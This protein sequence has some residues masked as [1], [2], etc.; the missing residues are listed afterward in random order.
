[1]QTKQILTVI[2]IVATAILAGAAIYFGLQ[3]QQE[4]SQ[5]PEGAKAAVQCGAGTCDNGQ[6]YGADCYATQASC[7]ERTAEYC[8]DFGGPGSGGGPTSNCPECGDGICNGQENAAS[9]P[10]DCQGQVTCNGQVLSNPKC[11]SGT[12]SEGYDGHVCEGP[13]GT[14]CVNESR[15][16]CNE[17]EARGYASST[18]CGQYD[19][20]CDG[21]VHEWE[22]FT[23]GCQEVIA[24]NGNC[25]GGLPCEGNATCN[26]DNICRN[27]NCPSDTD[28]VCDIVVTSLICGQDCTVANTECPANTSCNGGV[29]VLDT[30]IADPSLCNGFCELLSCPNGVVDTGEECDPT[31]DPTGCGQDQGCSQT[32]A[33]VDIGCGVPCDPG[34]TNSCLG[35]HLCD[36]D[37]NLCV[38]P[39]CLNNPEC[40]DNGCDLPP[41]S[42]PVTNLLTNQRNRILFSILAIIVGVLA[43]K[44]NPVDFVRLIEKS[45]FA[46]LLSPVS[47]KAGN[48]VHGRR[49]N[50]FEETLIRE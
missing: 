3:L 1:M 44:F 34:D 15:S 28:C 40:T 7:E 25:A 18:G 30:C 14:V 46:S 32:C 49:K 23:D 10:G 33:C 2:L 27:S 5:A 36:P 37:T 42:L 29:C 11:P 50:K 35:E 21:D 13:F 41:A 31:A 20:M 4:D 16:F 17:A 9:C 19:L 22:L 26:V 45:R 6:P 43:I 39:E 38:I 48:T 24:C 47:N 12:A 8:S